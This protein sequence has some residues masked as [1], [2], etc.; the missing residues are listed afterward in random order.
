MRVGEVGVDLSV[1][2]GTLSLRALTAERL[3]LM[4]ER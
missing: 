4:S 3:P 2:H 1:I